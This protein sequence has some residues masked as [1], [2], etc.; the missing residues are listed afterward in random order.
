MDLIGLIGLAVIAGYVLFYALAFALYLAE[1]LDE[2]LGYCR[3]R[4]HARTK[5]RAAKDSPWLPAMSYYDIA[6]L[7][8]SPSLRAEFQRKSEALDGASPTTVTGVTSAYP[9]TP[10]TNI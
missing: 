2:I 4:A 9:V 6:L 3:S 10:S 8:L 7:G 1:Q 5:A